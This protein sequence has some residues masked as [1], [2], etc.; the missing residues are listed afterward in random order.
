MLGDV[1]KTDMAE[2]LNIESA[3]MLPSSHI[4][5]GQIGPTRTNRPVGMPIDQSP[6]RWLTRNSALAASSVVKC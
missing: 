5:R 1:D 4:A 3:G 6:D 2:I